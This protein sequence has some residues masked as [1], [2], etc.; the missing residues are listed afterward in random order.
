MSNVTYSSIPY[1]GQAGKYPLSLNYHMFKWINLKMDEPFTAKD[2]DFG[3]TFSSNNIPFKVILNYMKNKCSPE[4]L[5]RLAKS[6]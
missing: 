5:L 3:T 1:K 6:S 4:K 2:L